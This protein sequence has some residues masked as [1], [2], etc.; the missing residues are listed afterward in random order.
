MCLFVAVCL[1]IVNLW[2]SSVR[3]CFNYTCDVMWTEQLSYVLR[4]NVNGRR[5]AHDYRP[6]QS[7]CFYEVSL[8]DSLAFRALIFSLFVGTYCHSCLS[9]LYCHYRVLLSIS[10]EFPFIHFVFI[11]ATF[12]LAVTALITYR[13][14][15]SDAWYTPTNFFCWS[16]NSY[17]SLVPG[18]LHFTYTSRRIGANF[19]V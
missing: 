4:L 11:H 13:A 6:I 8:L 10:V 12:I 19:W 15:I 7:K 9:D 14:C 5:G 16:I 17:M 2:M 3:V 1:F 18:T